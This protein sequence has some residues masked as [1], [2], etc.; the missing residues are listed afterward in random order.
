MKKIGA[1]ACLVVGVGLSCSVFAYEAG[2]WIV[3]A[4][5]TQVAPDESSSVVSVNGDNGAALGTQSGVS[6]DTN[7]QL[8]L[9]IQYMLSKQLGIELLAAT[10][11]KH[12]ISG[13]GDLAGLDIGET[14]QLPPTLS[15]VYYF[16]THSALMPYL[17]AGI[18]Y[19]AFFDEKPSATLKSA[20]G[21]NKMDLDNSFGFAVQV[22]VDYKINNQW[23]VNASVRKIDIETD[24]AIDLNNGDKVDVN[25]DI[26][27]FVYTLSVGYVF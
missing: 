2:D 8:G 25:V 21:A 12:K 14:K 17:G 18:N 19:T 6:V 1:S 23:L 4:G 16:D 26:D 10:P 20:L 24:A 27:P 3:R 13:S 9:N 22:G 11:F 15:A 5:V 7:E